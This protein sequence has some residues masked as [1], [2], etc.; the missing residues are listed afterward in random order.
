MLVNSLLRGLVVI[1]AGGQHVRDAIADEAL[2]ALDHLSGIVAGAARHDR[3]LAFGHAQ[4]QPDDSLLF[5]V[6]QR[7]GLAGGGQRHEKVHAPLELKF[8]EPFQSLEV[9]GP[10]RLERGDHGGADT[11]NG[12]DFHDALSR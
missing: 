12:A 10:V 8:D 1:G 11:A 6:G 7:R 3:H 4:R 5:L 9:H 2:A